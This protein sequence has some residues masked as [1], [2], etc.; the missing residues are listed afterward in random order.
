MLVPTLWA[1]SSEIQSCVYLLNHYITYGPY[2][3]LSK[4]QIS[5][6][7]QLLCVKV[8]EI[9]LQGAVVVMIVPGKLI[10]FEI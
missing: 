4:Y 1:E 6:L 8:A 5:Y 7:S 9:V 3:L 2:Y 10:V